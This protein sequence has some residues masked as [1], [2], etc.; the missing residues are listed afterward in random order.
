MSR[1][2]RGTTVVATIPEVGERVPVASYSFEEYVAA[3]GAALLRFTA[4]LGLWILRF[5]PA[6]VFVSGVPEAVALRLAN[7]ALK[8]SV[9][10]VGFVG[11]RPEGSFAYGLAHWCPYREGSPSGRWRQS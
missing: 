3:R 2:G 5:G 11:P 10:R 1:N 8:P 4:P 9:L 7:G 6:E